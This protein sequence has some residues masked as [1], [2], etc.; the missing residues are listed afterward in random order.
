MKVILELSCWKLS[1]VEKVHQTT[2]SE[3]VVMLNHGLVDPDPQVT[4]KLESHVGLL[5]W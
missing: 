3:N 1:S 2:F 5:S 4:W